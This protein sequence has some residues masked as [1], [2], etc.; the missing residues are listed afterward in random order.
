[1]QR[2]S[3]IDSSGL[4]AA[5]LRDAPRHVKVNARGA[6]MMVVAAALVGIGMWGG[7]E[8]RERAENAER[9]VA[10][11]SSERV[12]TGGDVIQLRKRGGGNDHS[13]T[14]HYRYVAHGRELAGAT[15]LRREEREKYQV[16]SPVGVWYLATEP[17]TSWLDGYSPR[18]EASWPATVVPLGCGIGAI[19]LIAIVRRQ[20]TLLTFGRPAMAT[21]T[22]VE[23]KKSDHGTYWRVH[24]EWTT[25]SGA[26]REGK[27]NHS[28]KHAPA[29]G[30]LM[31]IVYDRDDTFRHRRYPMTFV[32]LV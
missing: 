7:I 3:A 28:R 20:S 31:P 24:Y 14:A 22:K 5:L 12:L 4:P 8:L 30:A 10:L 25:M 18:L 26:T 6:A 19:A 21:I 23:K 15:R 13:I 2:R 11:F 27:Y 1:M 29:V 16:G 9:H 32:R 17:E